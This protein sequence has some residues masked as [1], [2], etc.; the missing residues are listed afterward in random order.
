MVAAA[1][2][3]DI[4]FACALCSCARPYPGYCECSGHD[5]ASDP[6]ITGIA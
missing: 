3:A 2:A 4:R 5:H 1:G 6:G